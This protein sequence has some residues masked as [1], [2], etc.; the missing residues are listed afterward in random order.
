MKSKEAYTIT[1]L[2]EMGFPAKELRDIA[3]SENFVDCGFKSGVKAFFYLPEL[4]QELKRR[5]LA[6]GKS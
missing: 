5:T 4:K 6:G 2:K 3:R 1:E